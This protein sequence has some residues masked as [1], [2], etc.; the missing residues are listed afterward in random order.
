MP[1]ISFGVISASGMA[2]VHMDA[3]RANNDARLEAICDIDLAKAERVAGMLGV[4][5]FFKDYREMLDT[6]I[7]AVVVCTPDQLHAE[8]TIAAL[9]AGKH[10]LCEKPMALTVG[11]CKAMVTAAEKA[12]KKLMVGQVCRYAP[13]FVLTKNLI[14]MGRIGELFFV[15]SEYA[16]DYT[17]SAGVGEWRKDPVNLR[18]PVVG[19]GCH[20][21][22]LLR[23]IAGNPSEVTAYANHKV[24]TT[25]P[26]DDCS[27]AIFRFPQDVIGKVFVSIGCKR[28]YTMRS[29]FYGNKGTIIADNT[30]P[31][32]TIY[33]ERI[34]E[35]GRVF[36]QCSEHTVGMQLPVAVNSH[37]VA[38]EIRVFVDCIIND[39]PVPTDGREGAAT[40]AVCNAIVQSAQEKRAVTISYPF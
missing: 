40:V 18:H 14:D 32:I 17:N 33:Q 21:V 35:N 10:V 36:P 29:V 19:G 24:L 27:V 12:K 25:W 26:V 13:G 8:Q 1:Q 30:S 31:F 38:S 16:H 28:N 7:D 3:I 2:R 15:E 11:E 4:P 34:A 22:D 20:A 23:W 9:Q 37:N 39:K 5:R 6:D